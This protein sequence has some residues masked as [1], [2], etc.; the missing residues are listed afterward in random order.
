MKSHCISWSITADGAHDGEVVY[1]AVANRH[2][3][4]EI[5]I[6]PRATAVPNETTTTQ[7]DGHIATIEE[8]GRMGLSSHSRS[9]RAS[10]LTWIVVK[11]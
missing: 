10:V 7:R 3:D 2:P 11:P 6:P 9:R 1:D 8:H 4:A 5:I